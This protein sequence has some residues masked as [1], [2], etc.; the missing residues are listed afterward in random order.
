VLCAQA[1]SPFRP[2]KPIA[3]CG[4][5]LRLV[6]GGIA[7][8]AAGSHARRPAFN[9]IREFRKTMPRPHRGSELVFS[10]SFS[11]PRAAKSSCRCHHTH[12]THHH[13]RPACQSHVCIVF[14]VV[15]SP[16]AYCGATWRS[17]H[18]SCTKRCV[19]PQLDIAKGCQGSQHLL[20]GKGIYQYSEL[21]IAAWH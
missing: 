14:G 18:P 3:H 9:E 4:P 19:Y 2:N 8:L 1:V 15:T 13:I 16:G 17:R 20:H 11:G 5:K 21:C 10:F 7:G 6:S 12:T